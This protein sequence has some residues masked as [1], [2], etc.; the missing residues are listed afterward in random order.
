MLKE[1]YE[2]RLEP[3]ERESDLQLVEEDDDFDAYDAGNEYI[4]ESAA[5]PPTPKVNSGLKDN[6]TKDSGSSKNIP[7]SYKG[8]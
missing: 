4:R 5:S 3:D 8:T 2:G 1:E 7:D 6:S